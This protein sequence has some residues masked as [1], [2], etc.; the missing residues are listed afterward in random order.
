MSGE[1]SSA[2]V[3]A[4]SS[5]SSHEADSAQDQVVKATDSGTG[6]GSGPLAARRMPSSPPTAAPT[7]SPVSAPTSA[8]S[9]TAA[10][11]AADAAQA[12]TENEE[13]SN[14]GGDAPYGDGRDRP[15]KN[16]RGKGPRRDDRPQETPGDSRSRVAVP[17]RR[18]PLDDDLQRDLDA[19]LSNANF[20]DLLKSSPQSQ[21]TLG[22]G[23][24]VFGTV[25]KVHDDVV[26][27]ALGGPHEGVVP[28]LQFPEEPAPGQTVEVVVRAY[29]PEDGLYV[30]VVPGKTIAVQDWSDLQE[31][32]VV[33]AYVTGVNSGGLEVRVGNVS[34]FMPAGQVAEHRIEDFSEFVDQRLTCLITESSERRNR[35]VVSRRAVLERE[36]EAKRQEQLA[37]IS[38]GDTMEGTVRSV[39][40]FGAFV[41]LGGLEGLVHVSRLSWEKIK[42]PS[43]V[44]QE[45]QKVKV[46]IEKIDQQTGKIGLSYRD[47]LE[48]PWDTAEQ[49]FPVGSIQR[50]VVSRIANY[51]AFVKLAPGV[52]G[53][54][55]ISELAHHRVFKV[56]N[57]VKEGPRLKSR[58][59]GLNAKLKR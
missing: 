47:L 35:L 32:A 4:A 52:E 23:D 37:K 56:D 5:P 53:L 16:R 33:E 30:V 45:G 54:V 38:V 12:H 46:K 34:G 36:R 59:W 26:F 7:Q 48:H 3:P 13:T 2:N 25:I 55:H 39:K 27:V 58:S 6:R 50:G 9:M 11:L 41:D 10:E 19:A 15:R 40:D 42:H 24:R 21:R 17:N 28:V 29:S 57:H 20:D 14:S 31:G 44:L 49:K 22:E 51:G 43:E 8:T 1:P 18:G